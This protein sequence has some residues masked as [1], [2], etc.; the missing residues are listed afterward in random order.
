MNVNIFSKVT[1]ENLCDWTFSENKPNQTQN[2][3]NSNPITERPKMNVNISY[4]M[5]YS[6]KTAFRRITNKPNS[7]PIKA[8]PELAE[9]LSVAEG[10]SRIGQSCPP[11]ADSDYPCVFELAVYNLVLRNGNVMHRMPNGRNF[12]GEYIKWQMHRRQM[13]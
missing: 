12:N 10:G 1:Y 4:T 11:Q 13:R 5:D 8:C 7:N 9:A 2:K 6:N 3:P